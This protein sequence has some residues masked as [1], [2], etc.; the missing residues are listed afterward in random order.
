[1]KRKRNCIYYYIFCESLC[2]KIFRKYLFVFFNCELYDSFFCLSYPKLF[3]LHTNTH[4]YTIHTQVI[5][6]IY[7]GSSYY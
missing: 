4:T 1:M 7:T 5:E 6:V 3:C 2:N